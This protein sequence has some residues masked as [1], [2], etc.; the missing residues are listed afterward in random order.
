MRQGSAKQEVIYN[1]GK[2][3]SE[4]KSKK[5][6]TGISDFSYEKCSALFAERGGD[7]IMAAKKKAKKKAK[8]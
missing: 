7:L 3:K 1:G 4:E 6:S 8:K 5:V 2:E